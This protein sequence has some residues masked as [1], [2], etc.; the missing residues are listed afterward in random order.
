MKLKEHLCNIGFDNS[1]WTQNNSGMWKS[2]FK[3]GFEAACEAAN[4]KDLNECFYVDLCDAGPEPVSD[5]EVKK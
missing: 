2:G 1:R 5:L 3:A 4:R